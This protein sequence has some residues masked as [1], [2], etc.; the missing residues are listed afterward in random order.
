MD[1]KITLSFNKHVIDKAK[2][3]AEAHNMSLS[4]MME[5]ILDKITIKPYAN[6]EELPISSWVDMLSEG[7]VQYQITQKS[8]KEIKGQ[9][10]DSKKPKKSKSL[11]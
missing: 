8:N 2:D 3:Y 11:K 10:Y 5:F 7:T 9:Y 4:R 6:L 1:A